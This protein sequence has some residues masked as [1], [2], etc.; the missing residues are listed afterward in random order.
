VEVGIHETED[1]Y[2]IASDIEEEE[3]EINKGLNYI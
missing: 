1:S 3:L 2:F